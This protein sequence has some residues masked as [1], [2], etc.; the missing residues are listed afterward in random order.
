MC[1]TISHQQWQAIFASIPRLGRTESGTAISAEVLSSGNGKHSFIIL[2]ERSEL[3][4][5][6]TIVNKSGTGFKS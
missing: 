4:A 6:R 3:E 2:E 5:S 1:S